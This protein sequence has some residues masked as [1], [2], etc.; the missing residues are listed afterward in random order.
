MG[1]SEKRGGLESVFR[2]GDTPF[3]GEIRFLRLVFFVSWVISWVLGRNIELFETTLPFCKGSTKGI[4]LGGEN[5]IVIEKSH[6][7]LPK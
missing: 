4:L 7:S 2:R 3:H 1:P 5:G 6:L